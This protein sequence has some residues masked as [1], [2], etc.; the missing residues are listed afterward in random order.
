MPFNITVIGVG[1]IGGS[2]ALA[3]KQ[4]GVDVNIVG[5]SR[6]EANLKLAKKLKVIDS[7]STDAKQ[8]V[9]NADMVLLCIPMKAMQAVMEN[10]KPFLKQHCIISDAGSVKGSFIKDALAVFK[11]GLNIVPGHPIA[12]KQC[13][14]VAEAE[15]SLFESKR[16]I[17]TP[18]K[19]SSQKAIDKVKSL[20]TACGANVEIMNAQ[21][22]DEI[23]AST[24]HLPHVLAF[25]LVNAL[26]E[27][28]ISSKDS[29][30]KEKLGE[31]IFKYAA[32]GFRD[33]SRIAASDPVMWKD[34]CMTNK[35]ALVE[36]IEVFQKECEKMKQAIK[37]SDEEALLQRFK[38]SQ[39]IRNRFKH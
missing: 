16:V 10:I 36:A 18:L 29:T 6:N 32:G 23:L 7:W 34:I 3:L 22:H 30:K 31:A 20:W 9:Q 28:K 19:D 38:K 37:Q 8:A 26:N 13:S 15:A 14:G 4:Q 12:G 5:F 2:F 21:K 39:E 17:L 25:S 11:T 27:I 33:F 1:L 24:S 35:D